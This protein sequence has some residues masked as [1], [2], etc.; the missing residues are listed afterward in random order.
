MKDLPILELP[1]RA[2]WE[3]WLLANHQ[4]SRGVWLKIAKKGS[5]TA[6]VTKAEAVDEAVS[7]GWIDGQL[8]NQDHQFFRLRLPPDSRAAGGP[9]ST[10]SAHRN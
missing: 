10:A 3:A 2:A 8:G 4:S 6:T 7:F 9:R 1:D 5:R